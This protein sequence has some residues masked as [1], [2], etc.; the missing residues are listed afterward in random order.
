MENQLVPKML[1]TSP[2]RTPTSQAS[3][4]HCEPDHGSDSSQLPGKALTP[5]ANAARRSDVSHPQTHGAGFG[6]EIVAQLGLEDSSAMVAI[7]ERRKRKRIALHWP[8][9]LF[10]EPAAPSVESTTENLTSNGFYC[11]SREPFQMGER[12]ECIIAIPAGSFGYNESP[13]RLQCR[14][15]VA[16]VED[17]SEGFGIGCYIEDYD[18][19]TNSRSAR[20]SM[21]PLEPM[22]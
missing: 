3:T 7:E 15:R 21:E 19:L 20:S 2:S 13:I 17:Q 10:R 18:L 5:P 8:V 11:I 4:Q 1:P 12:L 22:V 14:V 9:R 16:R 6:S